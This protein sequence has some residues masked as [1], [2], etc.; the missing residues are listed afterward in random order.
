LLEART[1]LASV[2]RGSR[3]DAHITN[4]LIEIGSLRY[5]VNEGDLA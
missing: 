1:V 5:A 4:A 2:K 3:K